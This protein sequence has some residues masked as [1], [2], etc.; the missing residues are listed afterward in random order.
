MK[1][2]G[3]LLFLIAF[4]A[5]SMG[6]AQTCC[7]GGVPLSNNLGLPNEGQGVLTLGISYDYNNLNTLNAGSDKLDDDSRLRITNSVL[8]SAGYAFTDRFSIESLLTWVNQLRTISQFGNETDT[9]TTGIGDGVFLLKYALPDV[10]GKESSVSLGGGV[11]VPFGRSDLLTAQGIQLTAD[12]QPGSGAWDIV[13]LLSISKNLGFRPS[14][15]VSL[16]LTARFTGTNND[17]LNGA[18][19]YEFG[20]AIQANL[21]YSDQFLGLGTIFNPSLVIKY[22]KAFIDKIEGFDL[23]NT[24]GEWI[25]VRPGI[26]VA[27]SPTLALVSKLEVPVYSFVEGTQLTPTLRFTG[28]LFITLNK[29]RNTLLNN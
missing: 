4:F 11:K 18:S 22:R 20:D 19:S 26:S 16:H 17:Y 27:I 14:S 15:M 12:L 5:V 23:P 13:G 7:S 2:L 24:G 8:V 10:L 29:N 1:I 21:G 3:S 9:E 28:G 25:F 6:I